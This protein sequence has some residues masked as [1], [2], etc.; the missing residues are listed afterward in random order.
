MHIQKIGQTI[1]RFRQLHHMTQDA[2]AVGICTTSYLS[3][4]ENGLVTANEA[5]YTLLFERLQ[6]NYKAYIEESAQQAELL[7]QLYVQLLSNEP[8]RAEHIE[9]LRLLH[10]KR[11]N[12]IVQVQADLVYGRYLLSIQQ[13]DEAS[14]ILKALEHIIIC[15]NTREWQLFVAVQAYY[16]LAIGKYELILEREQTTNSV[17]YLP[18]SF[19]K[20]NYV[21]HL[22]FASHRAYEFSLAKH[23]IEQAMTLFTHTYKP[24]FQLKLYSMHGVILNSL[25]NTNAALK[26]YFAA[27]ELLQCVPAIATDSQWASLY[28]NLAFTYESDKQYDDAIYYYEQSLRYIDDAH[29]YINYVRTLLFSRKNFNDALKKHASYTFI[30]GS[31]QYVQL[32]LIKAFAALHTEAGLELFYDTE[33]RACRYFV[34]HEHIELILCY[35]S[36]VARI[37]EERN[38]YKRAAER[39]RLLFET[40]EKM[41]MRVAKGIRR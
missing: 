10:E 33:Q 18:N 40:S 26:E 21:Y 22:A 12:P 34:E 25:Q 28:N 37:Y 39:Y 13:I 8:L 23:Y 36:A 4:I 41:R 35:G 6:L 30:E 17:H 20:A 16:E 7:E 27:I 32:Q 38:Q 31:H 2:L 19:E 3:R 11:T 1:K 9:Q 5:V 14:E 15:G 29:T 24:L